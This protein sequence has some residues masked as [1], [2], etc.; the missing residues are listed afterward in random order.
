MT[1]RESPPPQ[2]LE[3]EMGALGSMMLDDIVRAEILEN[4]TAI[5]FYT[6]AHCII[7]SAIAKLHN[8]G[9]PVDFVLVRDELKKRGKIDEVGGVVYLVQLGES[10][11]SAANGVYYARILKE[12]TAKRATITEIDVLSR[13]AWSNEP[14]DG[15]LPRTI[16]ALSDILDNQ[17]TEPTTICAANVKIEPVQW[18]W[19]D[20]YAIGKVNLLAGDPG[21]GK[22][23]LSLAIAAHVSVGRNWPTG[24][25]VM[26]ADV[27]ILSLE[28]TIEDT[29]VPRLMAQKA[30]LDR[31][32]LI[33][34]EVIY[35]KKGRPFNLVGDHLTLRRELA[36][37]P[38]TR[39]LIV[40]TI[41]AAMGHGENNKYTDVQQVMAP[42]KALAHEFNVCVIAI[43]HMNKGSGT[44]AAYRVHGSVANVAAPRAVWLVLKDPNDPTGER[45]LMM[46]EKTNLAPDK[47]IGQAFRI[48]AN[49]VVEMESEP[50]SGT[51]SEILVQTADLQKPGIRSDEIAFLREELK[52]GQLLQSEVKKLAE[53]AGLEWWKVQKAMGPA[54]VES[55]QDGWH[56]PFYWSLTK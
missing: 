52:G 6:P 14:L 29:I 3:A 17:S 42:L 2:S 25:Y 40:D 28:D 48:G 10:T 34:S 47:N 26:A 32:H 51:A 8:D 56:G 20:R 37:F 31:I 39:L 24:E 35:K 21:V 11:P 4:I 27:M 23:Y 19:Q 46:L 44:N 54:G 41:G 18:L 38:E 53:E 7:F 55:N 15:Q 9:K 33:Q 13:A 49:G 36:K 45:R 5:D 43:T 12:K 1:D 50:V 22:S 16:E 30:D